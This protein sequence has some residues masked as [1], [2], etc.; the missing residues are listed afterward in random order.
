MYQESDDSIRGSA[1]TDTVIIILLI[2]AFFGIGAIAGRLRSG[3]DNDLPIYVF[4]ILCA[5][6]V[7]AVYRLRVV[8]WRYTVFYEPPQTEYDPRFDD[9]ITHE[10][11][12]YPVGTFAVERTSSAKGEIYAVIDR[13]NIISLLAP[14]ADYEK[15]DSEFKCCCHSIKKS[16]SLVYKDGDGM[17]CRM[18]FSPSDELIK[19]LNMIIEGPVT[20]AAQE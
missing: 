4:G 11:Y 9:Y 14:G 3:F 5:I 16:H 20:D 6:C 17:T 10:D 18:Y 15:T 8:G 7:Y 13:A 2:A 19:Y 12:P 1:L